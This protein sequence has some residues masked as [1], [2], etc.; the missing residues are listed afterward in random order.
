M[1]SKTIN[2]VLA[3]HSMGYLVSYHKCWDQKQSL[4]TTETLFCIVYYY[5]SPVTF[6]FCT[7]LFVLI[8]IS[9]FIVPIMSAVFLYDIFMFTCYVS[10][11]LPLYPLSS[12][13]LPSFLPSFHLKQEDV[14]EHVLI[15]QYCQS[16]SSG[17]VKKL[18]N[19]N[20]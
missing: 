19:K 8:C 18:V 13:F 16:L 6:W 14:D 9:H 2:A 11:V 12:I 3:L 10:F 15:A 1:G 17:T 4:V 20:L 5:N 7:F